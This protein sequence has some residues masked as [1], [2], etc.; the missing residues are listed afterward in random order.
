[1]DD[2]LNISVVVI[3]RN[4]E[5]C[6]LKCLQSLAAQNYPRNNYEV[7]L[8]DNGSTDGTS[9]IARAFMSDFPNFRI[10][11]N[12]IP[13]IAITRNAGIHATKYDVV[14]FIDADCE[15]EPVWLSTLARAFR[16]ETAKDSSIAAVGGP[17][18]MPG[19]TSVFRHA[20]AV[21][22]TNYWGHHDSVQAKNPNLRLEV[23]HLPT[24][25]VMYDRT[26]VLEVG[27]FDE[28]QGNISEDVDM[29]HRLRD[30]GYK[31]IFEPRA[32]VAHRW[33]EDIWS[34]MKNMEVYGK[35][36]TWL[37]RKDPSHIKPQFAAPILLL[38]AFVLAL[39]ALFFWWLAIPLAMY[40][41][42]TFL[43]SLYACFSNG[44]PQFFPIVFLVYMVT[45]ISYGVG[46]IHGLFA[47]RGS[48]T[49][50]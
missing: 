7:V 5:D 16:E 29:S 27:L 31:L 18:V 9:E 8:V 32:I 44:K 11:R 13:G 33:R 17:N 19:K 14:A 45:H 1:M 37:M 20:L 6:I 35:G 34:W 48:D 2:P 40:L 46:Q 24:L 30:K 39:C 12:Q 25:N 36:R 42:L 50:G 43:V 3:A 49:N 38:T 47:K 23:D 15:A 22:T 10:V 21:A 41:I 28:G 26:K 4:E